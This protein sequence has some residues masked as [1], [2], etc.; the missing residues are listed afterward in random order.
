MRDSGG[1]WLQEVEL[2]QAI[3]QLPS[4][5]SLEGSAGGSVGIPDAGIE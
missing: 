4:D 3:S 5:A 2:R 1:G